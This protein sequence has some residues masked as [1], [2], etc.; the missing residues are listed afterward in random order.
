MRYEAGQAYIAH[1]DYFPAG[2]SDDHNWD[3]QDG[4]SNRFAT[5]FLYL[6]DVAHGGQTVFPGVDRLQSD[7]EP[8]SADELRTLMKDANVGQNSWE[9]SLA[10]TY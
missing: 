7:D 5:I 6:S 2:Q 8:P 10:R 1:N 3:P 9:G 4:G